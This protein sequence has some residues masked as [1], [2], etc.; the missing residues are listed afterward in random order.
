[1]TK[2]KDLSYIEINP[3]LKVIL[4]H[5]KKGDNICI[6][7]PGGSGKTEIVNI[8]AHDP[9]YKTDGSTIYAGSTGISAI[10]IT[11]KVGVKASTLHRA[12]EFD[13]S[14]IHPEDQVTSSKNYKFFR[15][16]VTR[17]VIDEISMVRIDLIHKFL[18]S[19]LGYFGAH[20]LNN[21]EEALDRIKHIQIILLGDPLQLESILKKDEKN[22]LL[23]DFDTFT[24][25]FFGSRL[26]QLM[27]FKELS[28]LKSYRTKHVGYLNALRKVRTGAVTW[29]S[30][31]ELSNHFLISSEEEY[32]NTVLPTPETEYTTL[33]TTNKD[34]E[35]I[36]NRE[37]AKIDEPETIISTVIYGD[38]KA[39]EKIVPDEL[40]LKKGCKVMLRANAQNG[41][42]VNGTI[43][44]IVSL[45]RGR[46]LR[47]NCDHYIRVKVGSRTFEIAPYQW[48]ILGPDEDVIGSV[49]QFPLNVCY[50]ITVHKS[51]GLQFE[52][53]LIN[54]GRGFFS[55]GQL[56]TSL[57]RSSNPDGL[58]L[59]K[60]ITLRDVKVDKFA[61]AWNNNIVEKSEDRTIKENK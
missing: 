59:L 33:C 20:D 47:G 37:M 6:L 1:M 29:E 7:G 41:S 18:W 3:E 38:V 42:Y 5:V 44:T 9:E 46:F 24:H 21:V 11:E 56:Y 26:Y 52:Y 2:Q 15:E 43:G 8:L 14:K 57:S 10:N 31:E 39:S 49:I 58:R 51:Q 19:L 34:V 35:V 32:I 16:N 13:I 48:D 22:E 55:C 17:I 50:A 23:N 60:P 4:G 25:Y 27:N 28:L 40:V 53:M 36:N 61:L 45:P 54:P 12:M 30:I